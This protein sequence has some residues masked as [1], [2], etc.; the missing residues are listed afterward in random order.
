MPAEGRSR[1]HPLTTLLRLSDTIHDALVSGGAFASLF[2]DRFGYFRV[3]RFY[4]RF[5]LV[6]GSDVVGRAHLL[7]AK[8]F[9]DD[10]QR[11]TFL[12]K[13]EQGLDAKF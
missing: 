6:F 9:G 5:D 11:V 10:P 4:E 3:A 2:Y 13:C 7:H 12:P 1:V 8:S